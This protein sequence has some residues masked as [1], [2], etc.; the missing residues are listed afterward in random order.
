M[1]NQSRDMSRGYHASIHSE[2]EHQN[3]HDVN[4]NQHYSRQTEQ[5]QQDSRRLFQRGH[6]ASSSKYTHTK[7]K[8][9]LSKNN[10]FLNEQTFGFGAIVDSIAD[11]HQSAIFNICELGS[12]SSLNSHS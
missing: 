5:H 6:G 4:S 1:Y 3:R 12:D 8:L 11:A 9:S 10:L 2:V 7:N